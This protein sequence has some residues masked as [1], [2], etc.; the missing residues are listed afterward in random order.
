MSVRLRSVDSWLHVASTPRRCFGTRC[1]MRRRWRACCDTGHF[2]RHQGS[3]AHRR[4]SA[5]DL[6]VRILPGSR[7]TKPHLLKRAL[8]ETGRAYRCELCANEGRWRG[9]SLVLEIDHVDGDCHNNEGW[10]LRFLCPNCH[11]QTDGFSGRSRGKWVSRT[12]QLALFGSVGP[13]R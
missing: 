1:A 6:L 5:K 11:A 13:G 3:G 9:R 12:G 10:N 2:V 7:R 8:L 4:R